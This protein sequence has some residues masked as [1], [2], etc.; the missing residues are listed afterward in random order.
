MEIVDPTFQ[1]GRYAIAKYSWIKFSL[2][3]ISESVFKYVY[4][5][6]M[7]PKLSSQSY[8]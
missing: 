6:Q 7:K 5:C 2:I 4:F 3:D 8:S 1:K